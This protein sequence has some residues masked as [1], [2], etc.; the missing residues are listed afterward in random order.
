MSIVPAY[1]RIFISII[2]F[3]LSNMLYAQELSVQ[4]SL[5]LMNYGGDLQNKVYTLQQSQFS[6]GAGVMYRI[7]KISIRGKFTYGKVKGDDLH[8]T[9]FKTRNL[10]FASNI[11][12]VNL[13][14]QYDFKL[15]DDNQKFTPY[16]FAGVGLF[17]FNPY[18]F[19]DSQKVFLQPLG[20]E[21]QG[22]SIYPDKKPYSLTQF[23]I[24][25]GVGVKYKVSDR[26][27]LGLEFNSR[28]LFT[29]YLDD[30]SDKYPDGNELFKQNGQLA[31]N[32]S[33]R[34]NEIDPGLTFPS[35]NKRGNASQNDNYYTSSFSFIYVLPQQSLFSGGKKSKR[36]RSIDCPKD[37]Q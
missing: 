34:G 15:L 29:D 12:E 25:I 10:S 5:G 33:F 30:V 6:I 19:Y 9:Q 31:V 13:C 11:S 18:A 35:G 7:N 27:I 28:F 14:L 1:K 2:A 20:T 32:L 8:N 4:V 3:I 24:P 22:L 36:N 23:E 21:G 37:V 26:I 17:H 16:I